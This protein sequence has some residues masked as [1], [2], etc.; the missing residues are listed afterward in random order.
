[1]IQTEPLSNVTKWVLA[2]DEQVIDSCTL[3]NFD[4]ETVKCQKWAYNETYYGPNRVTQVLNIKEK[5]HFIITTGFD[6][7][8]QQLFNFLFSYI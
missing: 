8:L 5:K 2:P 4:N 6:Q 7:S 3:R 1:M